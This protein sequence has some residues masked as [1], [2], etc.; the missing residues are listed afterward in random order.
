M[1]VHGSEWKDRALH[2]MHALKDNMKEKF[3][4]IAD[5]PNS[6]VPELAEFIQQHPDTQ[7]IRKNLLG[8]SYTFYRLNMNNYQFYLETNSDR[9][10]QL[11][12]YSN[13]TKFVSHRSYRDFDDLDSPIKLM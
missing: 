8:N 10:L 11:D 2:A 13:G 1:E 5:I 4:S 12:G 6:T 7:V 3:Y 9:V